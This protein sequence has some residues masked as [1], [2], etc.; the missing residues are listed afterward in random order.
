MA[1]AH[2]DPAQIEHLLDRIRSGE[3]AARDE[4]LAY[5]NER[6]RRL[7]RRMLRDFPVVRGWE[8]T[9]DILQNAQIRLWQ[10][11]ERLTPAGAR[12]F[13][14]LASLQI[15]RELLDLARHYAGPA[16]SLTR[17][18]GGGPAGDADSTPPPAEE[19]ATTH[20]PG[21]LAE[22]TE[23]HG[24]VDALPAEEQELFDLLWYQELSQPEAAAVLG[25]SLATFKRRWLSARRHL[26]QR[27]PGGLPGA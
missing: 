2:P 9:D 25:V 5:V 18:A 19:G 1:T 6:L 16:G 13:Y 20:E 21:R 17:R 7:A 8:E 12:E 11:L 3:K 10:A 14:G 22:W 27:L 4:L 23:F 15:R 26:L 24:Q